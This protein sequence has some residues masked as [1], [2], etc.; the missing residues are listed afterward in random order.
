MKKL[1]HKRSTFHLAAAVLIILL[2]AKYF[3][4]FFAF[5]GIPFGYDAGIYRY[6]FL[7][8]AEGFPPFSVAAMPPWAQSH[9]LG[10]F[11]FSTIFIR[12]RIPA[13]W[14]IGW[15]WNIFPVILSLVLAQIFAKRQGKLVGLLI[16]LVCLL[17]TVQYQGFLMIYWKVFAAFLFCILSFRFFEQKSQWWIPFGMLVIATHLQIGL[18]FVLATLCSILTRVP[19]RELFTRFSQ[20]LLALTLGLLWYLPN[21]DRAIG[22][23]LPLLTDSGVGFVLAIAVVVA[24]AIAGSCIMLPKRRN[25]ILLISGIVAVFLVLLGIPLTGYAPTLIDRIFSRMGSVQPGAFFTLPDYFA[26]SW[27]LLL[28]GI[29]GLV[30]SLKKEKGTVWQWA[31]FWCALAVVS[32]SF[33]YRRFLLPMDF[34]LLPFAALALEHLWTS[35]DTFSRVLVGG[36]LVAQAVL[37]VQ[38]VQRI[39]PYVSRAELQEIAALPGHVP[40]GSTVIVLD[41]L[42]PWVT[43]YLPGSA[44]SGPGI[45]DSQPMDAW[46]KFIYGTHEDRKTFL[47]HYPTGTFL[48]AS[49]IFRSYY[50]PETVEAVLSDSCI[51]PVSAASSPGLFVSVCGH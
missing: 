25:I 39:D 14:L 36:L 3:W 28:L 42:A 23:I 43:G 47:Q 40:V 12:L 15:V 41:I 4:S 7:K 24:L 18:V 10:L 44:V 1:L 31:V 48:F 19:R 11:F 26:V 35:R 33:F 30:L 27:P 9:P 32:M 46:E 51:K 22:D 5:P 21:A 16:L 2:L 8:H 50:P 13:D 17:S 6:L 49:D 37:Q 38:Q 45:F 29:A 20:W 34:F